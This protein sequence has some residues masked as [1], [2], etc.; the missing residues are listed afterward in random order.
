MDMKLSNEDIDTF[1]I[2]AIGLAAV[3]FFTVVA[4]YWVISKIGDFVWRKK[5]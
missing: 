1:L 5:K 2:C 4:L 3:G